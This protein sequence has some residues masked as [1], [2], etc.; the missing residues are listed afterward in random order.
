MT[1]KGWYAIK[2]KQPT[3]NQKI[4]NGKVK[5]ILRQFTEEELDTLLNKLK[6]EM[7]LTL[8]KHHPKFRRQENLTTYFSLY[9]T[10]SIDKTQ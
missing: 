5:V 6:S 9:A 4:I 8:T 10:Q 2:P 3:T 1:Y 7:L